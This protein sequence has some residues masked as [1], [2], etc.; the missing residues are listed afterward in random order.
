MTPSGPRPRPP[1]SAPDDG[2]EPS[3]RAD[4][5][6]ARIE[7][8]VLLFTGLTVFLVAIDLDAFEWLAAY[9]RRYEDYEVDEF[10]TAAIVMAGFLLV[11][12]ISR[13]VQL[14]RVLRRLERTQYELREAVAL[15]DRLRTEAEAATKA[16][17]NFLAATSHELRTPLNAI[18]GFAEIMR[19]RHIPNADL[20]TY[21]TYAGDIHR[22]TT[23]LL[24]ILEDLLDIS[25]VE[26]GRT[27]LTLEAVAV[28][29]VVDRCLN[30]LRERA[31]ERRL[32]ISVRIADDDGTVWADAHALLRMITNLV[33]NAIKYNRPGGSIVIRAGTVTP[34]RYEI[35]VSDTGIGI[36]R[37]DIPRML[38]P[39]ERGAGTTTAAEPGVGLGL[40]IVNT[41]MARHGGTVHVDSLVGEGTTVTL[42]F[43]AVT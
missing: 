8:L 4:R 43:P 23:D 9:T 11:F 15:S 28:R 33:T 42:R 21:A 24:A 17:S 34:A 12:S 26:A 20:D 19:D 31:R 35:S 22:S 39:Y 6:W 10:F 1:S 25:K 32:H 16:K 14:T 40:A 37:K 18:L 5:R 3:V 7:A 2:T 30:T 36:P 29:P 38:L 13:M 41:L 27:T